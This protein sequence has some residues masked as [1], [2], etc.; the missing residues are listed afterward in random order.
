MRQDSLVSTP[1]VEELAST[2]NLSIPPSE[3][4]DWAILLTG[5]NHCAKEVL[6]FPGYYPEVDTTLY[7]RINIHRPSG[8]KD[9]DSGGWTWKA[10]I[11]CTKQKSNELKGKTLAIKDSIALAGVKCTNGMGGNWESGFL[12]STPRS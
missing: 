12:T 4:Q 9:T 11:K 6:A 5:L 3:L 7:P 2:H 8:D 1:E 10:T